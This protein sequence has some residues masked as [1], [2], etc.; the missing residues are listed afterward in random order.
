MTSILSKKQKTTVIVESLSLGILLVLGSRHVPKLPRKRPR[1]KWNSYQEPSVT[2]LDSASEGFLSARLRSTCR[3]A[4]YNSFMTLNCSSE[5]EFS[6]SLD[7][8]ENPPQ[9]A[10]TLSR[11]NE[12][13]CALCGKVHKWAVCYSRHAN[14]EICI[15]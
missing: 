6:L 11:L 5:S 9:T 3:D 14:E 4:R 8:Q 1:P 12:D 15:H 10:Q 7:F 13:V 2:R